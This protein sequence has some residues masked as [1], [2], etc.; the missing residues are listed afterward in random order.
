MI[1][2]L[3]ILVFTFLSLN[4]ASFNWEKDYATA[5][6]KA[7][8]LNKPILVM[9]SSPTCP[10]C[11][12]MKKHVFVKDEVKNFVNKNFITYHFDIND[13]NIPKQMQFWGIPRFYFTKDGENVYKKAMGG[14]K[15][16]KFMA[17]LKENKK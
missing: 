1:K 3:T 8:E 12:Y 14:M 7:K 2:L 9:V 16:D 17:L 11:N 4:A 10:E 5:V 6:K 13:Q 15:E